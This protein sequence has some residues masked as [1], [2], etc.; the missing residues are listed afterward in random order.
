MKNNSRIRFNPVTKE[1]EVAGTEKFV[2]T[3]FGKLQSMI[4][5]T[6]PKT[7]K[8]KKESKAVEAAPKKKAEKYP[9]A[10][11]P[12]IA[13]KIKKTGKKAPTEKKVT[14]I[15]AVVSLIQGA[16]EGISTTELKEKTGLVESQIWSIVNHAA[17]AGKIRKVKRG[18][19]GGVAVVDAT[20]EKKAE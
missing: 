7:V 16:P 20:P 10:V 18:V 2:K 12:T 11:K 15:D 9:K 14:N 8:M 19:Y 4:S 1:I 17:K 13:K 3:Y 6:A 5:G